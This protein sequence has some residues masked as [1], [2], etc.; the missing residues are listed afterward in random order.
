MAKPITWDD[1]VVRLD[2]KVLI[3]VTE[4][5]SGTYEPDR[6]IHV[7]TW[8]GPT[9][10]VCCTCGQGVSYCTCHERGED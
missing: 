3:P 2:G 4:L 1:V 6:E 9:I 10:E 8:F 5:A 7:Q